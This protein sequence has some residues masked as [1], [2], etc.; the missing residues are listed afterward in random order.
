[1]EGRGARR[2]LVFQ[3]VRRHRRRRNAGV[4]LVR[5]AGRP[6]YGNAA[7]QDFRLD[8]GGGACGASVFTAHSGNPVADGP[9][10]GTSARGADRAGA[11]S[12]GQRSMTAKKTS[13]PLIQAQV[14]WL[15]AL[16]LSAQW[17][18]WGH[19]LTWNAIAGAAL[20]LARVVLP[21]KWRA[22]TRHRRWLLPLLAIAGALGIRSNLGY[23]LAR[24]PCVEFLYLLVGIKFIES[25]DTR[26]GTLLICLALFLAMTQ[27]FYLQTI[28]SALSMAPVLLALGGTLASLRAGTAAAVSEWRPQ[29]NATVRL[30]LQGIPLAA[31]VFI[32]FPRI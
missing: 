30:I 12:I 9:G 7:V 19:V 3:A 22:L 21:P 23:F 27:F 4:A 5:N 31:L 16:L 2:G 32:L 29:L 28:T 26:D 13:P 8:T 10:R 17:P 11:V 24:D 6:G 15:G 20:V 1:M 25:R 14:F 18:L